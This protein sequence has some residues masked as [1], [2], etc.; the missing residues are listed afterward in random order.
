MDTQ[1]LHSIL[2]IVIAGPNHSFGDVVP[3]SELP[4]QQIHYF[5]DG[6][7]QGGD[8]CPTRFDMAWMGLLT[9]EQLDGFLG[10]FQMT[11][12]EGEIDE[13][14]F[15][16]P[17]SLR[18]ANTQLYTGEVEDGKLFAYVNDATRLKPGDWSVYFPEPP[19]SR[20]HFPRFE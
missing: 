2:Y 5:E 14:K 9:Q 6:Y 20:F 8:F 18:N 4:L 13:P 11:L 17:H 12:Q 3:A 7:W 19:R 1:M 16:I 15:R 10:H